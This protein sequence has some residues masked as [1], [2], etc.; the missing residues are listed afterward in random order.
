MTEIQDKLQALKD[1]WEDF[2]KTAH[3]ASEEERQIFQSMIQE[4]D[5]AEIKLKREK[6]ISLYE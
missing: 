6:T 1:A 2:K 3:D 5:T 4:M